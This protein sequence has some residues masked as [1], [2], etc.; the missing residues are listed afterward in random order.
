MSGEECNDGEMK[1]LKCLI[2]RSLSTRC[3]LMP[4][5]GQRWK[6]VSLRPR[7]PSYSD[8]TDH[9]VMENES[10]G[11]LLHCEMFRFCFVLFFYLIQ[12]SV[13]NV[14]SLRNTDHC[15]VYCRLFCEIFAFVARFECGSGMKNVMRF[16]GTEHY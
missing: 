9:V 11:T 7:R 1:Q 2:T 13:Q 16:S 10:S 5:C 6:Q 14:T 12:A 15:I 3:T 4:S 8:V